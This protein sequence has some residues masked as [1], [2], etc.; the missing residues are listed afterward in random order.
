MG[1]EWRKRGERVR[2][3]WGKSEEKSEG[4]VGI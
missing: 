4:R 1:G 3:E 2:E